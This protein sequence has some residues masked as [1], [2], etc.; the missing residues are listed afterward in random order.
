MILIYAILLGLCIGSF[1][2]VVA[3]RT[4]KGKSIVYPPSQCDFCRHKLSVL[5][6][7]PVISFLWLRG[8]CRYCKKRLSWQYPLTEAATGLLFGLL[9][10][11]FLTGY[12]DLPY[13][14]YLLVTFSC[15]IV[16]IL[17][18]LKEQIILDEAIGIQ[19]FATVVYLVFFHREL[20]AISLLSGLGFFLFLLS[21]FLFTRGKGMGFGDVKFAFAMGLSLGFPK[22]V[23]AFYLSFLTG[24]FISLI[25]VM[26]RHKSIKSAIPFGPFLAVS[27]AVCLI[28][29]DS[30]WIY[31]LR[32]L[33][34]S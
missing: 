14:I 13:L 12:I 22:I 27:L 1:L 4:L 30:I 34:L 31:A 17:T 29:G 15:L 32:L 24:A 2:N 3:D 8:K 6:L 7:I 11:G 16:I 18:D 33:G 10:A 26:I 20:F 9:T 19:V 21:L 5:D 28:F 23:V 25:L